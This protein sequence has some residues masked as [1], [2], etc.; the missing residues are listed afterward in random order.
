MLSYFIKKRIVTV[1][2]ELSKYISQNFFSFSW[3]Y[4]KNSHGMFLNFRKWTVKRHLSENHTC[5]FSILSTDSWQIISNYFQ[6][7]QM[8]LNMFSCNQNFKYFKT[9]KHGRPCVRNLNIIKEML[10]EQNIQVIPN[11]KHAY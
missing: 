1:W 3:F 4:L 2:Y 11:N 7:F 6:E 8:S 10:K 9:F 5:L